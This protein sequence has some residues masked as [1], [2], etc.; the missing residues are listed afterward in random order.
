MLGC[1]Y[2]SANDDAMHCQWPNNDPMQEEIMNM[3][4]LDWYW[5]YVVFAVSRL[6]SFTCVMWKYSRPY[7]AYV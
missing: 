6:I 1:T 7:N 3:G 5:L 4:E 2:N